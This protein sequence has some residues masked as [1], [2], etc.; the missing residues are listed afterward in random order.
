VKCSA[1]Y[2]ESYLYDDGSEVLAAV[3]IA[4][5]GRFAR[6]K[7][8]YVRD[9]L[10]GQGIG[11]RV[12]RAAFAEVGVR[13]VIVACGYAHQQSTAHRLYR[14]CGMTDLDAQTEWTKPV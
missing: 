7:N 8:L 9:D 3:S 1:G 12:V 5:F 4:F 13:G 2:M 10:H 14:R 6:L 11:Q